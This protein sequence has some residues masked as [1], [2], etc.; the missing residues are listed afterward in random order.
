M[1]VEPI[2]PDR[3]CWCDHLYEKKGTRRIIPVVRCGMRTV[4]FTPAFC[5]ADFRSSEFGVKKSRQKC[6]M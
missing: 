2:I 3:N 1:K 5:P 4:H 6:R